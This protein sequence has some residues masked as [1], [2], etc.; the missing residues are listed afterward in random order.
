[1]SF[2]VTERMNGGVLVLA[3]NGRFVIGDAVEEFRQKV[4]DAIKAG[5]VQVG[6][7]FAR[8]EYIDSSGMGYLV[9]AHRVVGDAGGKLGMFNL[10][11]RVV[12]L[13]LLTKLSGVF[14]LYENEKDA[15]TGILGGD[16]KKMDLIAYVES[17][18]EHH[19]GGE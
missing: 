9:V 7:D 17:K 2:H 4:D 11:D 13:M 18:G 15:V 12:D 16:V 3:L 8:T 14:H 5:R 19:E 10:T 1:M 6:L